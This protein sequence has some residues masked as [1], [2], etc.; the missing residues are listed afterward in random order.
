M[1]AASTLLPVHS[2]TVQTNAS[3]SAPGDELHGTAAWLMVSQHPL[4][5]VCCGQQSEKMP[6]PAAMRLF[7]HNNGGGQTKTARL[8]SAGHPTYCTSADHAVHGIAVHV[9]QHAARL[10]HAAYT[11]GI[12]TPPPASPTTM[13]GASSVRFNAHAFNACTARL[14]PTSS[15]CRSSLCKPPKQQH[16]SPP[17]LPKLL[18]H[19]KWYVFGICCHVVAHVL[20]RCPTPWRATS[21]SCSLP[22][23][24]HHCPRSSRSP[25][26]KS[27]DVSARCGSSRSCRTMATCTGRLIPTRS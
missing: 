10:Q 8:P 7:F 6:T 14:A 20:P 25:P 15:I 18:A 23:N 2:A 27:R 22:Q 26:T 19:F 16:S 17:T 13:Q 12:C 11:F 9:S 3:K 21:S 24:S 1:A 5:L 4:V